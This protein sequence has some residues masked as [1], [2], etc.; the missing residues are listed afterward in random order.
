M[1]PIPVVLARH[2]SLRGPPRPRRWA[3]GLPRGTQPERA[4]FAG[5]QR[6]LAKALGQPALPSR[7]LP[8][9]RAEPRSQPQHG[10]P[11]SALTCAVPPDPRRFP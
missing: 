7:G 3:L 11:S 1:R 2:L 6:P 8:G 4:S 9:D 5:S 10:P